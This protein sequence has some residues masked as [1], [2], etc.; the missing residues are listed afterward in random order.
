MEIPMYEHADLDL[1]LI[2]KKIGKKSGRF[3]RNLINY[4]HNFGLDLLVEDNKFTITTETILDAIPIIE[5][6]E[7]EEGK[8]M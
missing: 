6:K 8:V 1:E 2:A 5:K 3:I 7:E 4:S